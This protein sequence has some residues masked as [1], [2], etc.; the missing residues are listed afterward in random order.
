MSSGKDSETIGIVVSKELKERL[1][2]LAE[3][4]ERTMSQLGGKF[5]REGVERMEA[6][7]KENE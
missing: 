4:D 1:R 2:K 5:I 3:E 7:K 6:K